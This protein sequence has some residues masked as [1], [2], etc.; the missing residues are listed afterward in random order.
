[1]PHPGATHELQRRSVGVRLQV[2]ARAYNLCRAHLQAR[3]RL[4]VA[5][6]VSAHAIGKGT[7]PPGAEAPPAAMRAASAGAVGLAPRSVASAPAPVRAAPGPAAATSVPPPSAILEAPVCSGKDVVDVVCAARS[8]CSEAVSSA[9]SATTIAVVAGVDAATRS[10][11][12]AGAAPPAAVSLRTAPERAEASAPEDGRRV[13]EG[14]APPAAVSSRAAPER[15][16]ASA[17][18]DGRRVLGGAA[19]ERTAASTPEDGRRVLGGAAPTAAVS[20]RAAP[21]RA[22][23]STPE[24]GRGASGREAPPA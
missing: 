24:N 11:A 5:E 8:S 13:L 21:E 17:P 9:D 2:T 1:M 15:A 18:E 12:P 10:L 19:P 20:S 4:P 14:A 7:S 23:A 22:A 6:D 3:R 16:E